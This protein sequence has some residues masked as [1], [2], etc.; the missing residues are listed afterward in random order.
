VAELILMVLEECGLELHAVV[1]GDG[2]EALDYLYARGRY[3]ETGSA[4]PAV[5]FLDLNMPRVGGLE[6]L[7]QIKQ[8]DRLSRI[9][10]VII[11]SSRDPA[12][13]ENCYGSGANAYVVK[14]IDFRQFRDAIR[15]TGA[16]W[17]SVNEPPPLPP[18]SCSDASPASLAAP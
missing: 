12:D 17:T 14:P 3:H 8:D 11:T 9:P 1:V 15:Q 13:L 6:V 16:F 10:V 18:Q 4:P 7:R 2:A 5:V